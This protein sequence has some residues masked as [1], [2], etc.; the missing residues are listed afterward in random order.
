[1]KKHGASRDFGSR[2]FAGGEFA[3]GGV[4][5]V[6][7]MG[8]DFDN[9]AHGADE[10]GSKSAGEAVTAGCAGR[11]QHYHDLALEFLVMMRFAAVSQ[12]RERYRM[13]GQHYLARAGA[14]LARAREDQPPTRRKRRRR[15]ARKVVSGWT[16][17]AEAFQLDRRVA[18]A[19]AG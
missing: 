3:D 2:D 6:D 9:G 1:M 12:V 11:A 15:T 14:E 7:V 5:S 16:K 4:A 13:M 8:M 10:G 18:A 19:K 17:A